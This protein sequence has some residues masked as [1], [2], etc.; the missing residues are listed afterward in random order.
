MKKRLKDANGRPTVVANDKPIMDSIMYEVE[1]RDG[2]VAAMAAKVISE[3]L[4][5]Q[6]DKE[7]NIFVM[8]E[9]IIDTRTDG[10]QKLQQDA[11]VITKSGTKRKKIQLNNGKSASNVRMAVLHGTNLKIS[12]IR[13]Q[14]KWQSTR[15]RIEFQRIH[16]SHGG[17]N[18]C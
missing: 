7:S 1:Y 10:T 5:A 15:L 2:Y 4:F 14:Y 18:T 3:N 17:L 6:V 12:R 9:S 11:F 16:N 8:I 13:I